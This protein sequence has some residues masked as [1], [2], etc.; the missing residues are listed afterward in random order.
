MS[1]PIR[2]RVLPEPP[3]RAFVQEWADDRR[4][5]A[6]QAWAKATDVPAVQEDLLEPLGL[7]VEALRPKAA[8]PA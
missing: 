8:E 7:A 1:T 2:Q 3:P 6:A 4:V 5:L